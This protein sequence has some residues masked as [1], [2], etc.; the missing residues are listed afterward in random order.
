MWKMGCRPPLGRVRG[1]L[2]ALK[3]KF[4]QQATCGKWAVGTPWEKSE[5][6]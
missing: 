3:A 5:A 1:I 6:F 4:K 2:N